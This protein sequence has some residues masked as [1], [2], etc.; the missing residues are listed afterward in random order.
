MFGVSSDLDESQVDKE[1][2]SRQVLEVLE[3]NL[4]A[5]SRN[6]S[7]REVW[8][9]HL[10][11]LVD[12]DSFQAFSDA[13]HRVAMAET[14]AQ[15]NHRH[16]AVT[17]SLKEALKI[18]EAQE[19]FQARMALKENEENIKSEAAQ[20][21]LAH[22]A[23]CKVK[24]EAYQ[25]ILDANLRQSM[26]TKDGEIAQ[27]R[28]EAM[29]RDRVQ[30]ERI[31][32]LEEL[33]MQQSLQNQKLQSLLDS[34]LS[35][36]PP[37]PV[38]ET[39]TATVRAEPY[40]LSAPLNSFTAA[41]SSNPLSSA[42]NRTIPY[43]NLDGDPFEEGDNKGPGDG[44]GPP[45]GDGGD[46]GNGGGGGGDTPKPSPSI[47][48]EPSKPNKGKKKAPGGGGDGGGDDD[49]PGKDSDDS[50]EKFVRRMKKFLGGGF[51]TGNSDDKPK[52][53][54]ADTIKLP[55]IPG[56]ETYRNWRIKTREAIA[57]A[58]TNPDYF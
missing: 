39:A 18:R 34:Q 43:E 35:Q 29:E 58:S 24:V 14:E 7:S 57:A 55:A 30:E 33:L 5:V 15:A 1:G 19:V 53:K 6:F 26:A 52:V 22:E 2:E 17:D 31:K 41:P 37:V 46:D 45:G 47:G 36:P 49:D 27:L 8:M 51:N 56:P 50:D 11:N 48:P 10:F 44:G 16:E 21:V 42:L 28:K 38:V 32:K 25:R 23:Q 40:V 12:F 20:H 3:Y 13:R 54:E 4:Q 9:I